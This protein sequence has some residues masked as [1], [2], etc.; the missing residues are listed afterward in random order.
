M[1]LL[2][3]FRPTTSSMRSPFPYEDTQLPW[4]RRLTALQTA[5]LCSSTLFP[6]DVL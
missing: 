5:F 4:L 1:F 2:S 6:L 3:F